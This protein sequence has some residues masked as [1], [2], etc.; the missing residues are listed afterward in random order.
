VKRRRLAG[1]R[2]RPAVVHG[3]AHQQAGGHLV[4]EQVN[5]AFHRIGLIFSIEAKGDNL[6]WATLCLMGVEKPATA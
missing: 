3:R 4:V 6:D 5:T 1:G 2:E